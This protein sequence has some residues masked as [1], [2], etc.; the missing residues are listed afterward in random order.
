MAIRSSRAQEAACYH[1]AGAPCNAGIRNATASPFPSPPSI[2]CW[3]ARAV[4]HP[5]VCAR[6]YRRHPARLALCARPGPHRAAVGRAGAADASSTSTISCCGSRSASSSAAASA[7]CCSTTCR[8]FAAHPLE[9]VQLWKG[10]MS[11]H[12]GFL[13]CVLA[14]VLFARSARHSD[15]LARR[16]HL[17]GRADRA[18]PR[19]HRQFHQRR[20]VGP[21][22]RRALGDG[23]SR[24]R[25]AAAP[26]EPALRGDAR[27]A[28]A[29]RVLG[30][31]DARRRAEAAGP[32]IGAFAVGYGSRAS[33]ANS[34][35]SPTRSSASSGAG[36]HGHCCRCR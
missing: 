8:Y 33:S 23:V 30:A 24:R 11:F 27:R 6:L 1:C 22:D 5:L 35:A 25:A 3:S 31:A 34:S 7:T 36:H 2:R 29:V 20:I 21:P 18:V 10:G 4:C 12:G 15:P 16:H 13:G 19:P 17:R 9:I 14:V 26:S 32:V 28:G